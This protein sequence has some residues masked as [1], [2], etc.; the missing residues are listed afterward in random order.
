MIVNRLNWL[1]QLD[2]PQPTS[3]PNSLPHNAIFFS[4]K[5]TKTLKPT[6]CCTRWFWSHEG[7]WRI[8]WVSVGFIS[9]R[10]NNNVQ[11]IGSSLMV[12]IDRNKNVLNFSF[13]TRRLSCTER[14]TVQNATNIFDWRLFQRESETEPCT[15]TNTIDD[16]QETEFK[17]RCF[18]VFRC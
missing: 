14:N 12:K 2:Q 4:Q 18:H 7:R 1:C 5:P 10:F 17:Y 6:N 8:D 15:S 13:R 11:T 9:M 16:L 3:E